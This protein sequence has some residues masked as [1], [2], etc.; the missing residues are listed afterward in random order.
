ML[1]QRSL[2]MRWTGRMDLRAIDRI[3]NEVDG[4]FSVC[5]WNAFLRRSFAAVRIVMP[6]AFWCEAEH[7]QLASDVLPISF[8]G[9]V[10]RCAE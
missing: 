4:L 9:P 7:F 3:R 2:H 6:I 8:V 1:S 5:G 10:V